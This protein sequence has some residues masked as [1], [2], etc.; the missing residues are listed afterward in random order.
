M[1]SLTYKLY[2]TTGLAFDKVKCT[3]TQYLFE[4]PCKN[5]SLCEPYVVL[6]NSGNYKIELWGASGGN[7]RKINSA[8]YNFGSAGNGSYVKGNIFLQKPTQLF[9]YLGGQGEDLITTDNVSYHMKGGWNFGGNG[10]NDYHDAG[11]TDPP[12]SGAGGGGGVDV[13]LEYYDINEEILDDRKLMRSIKSRIIVAGSGGGAEATQWPF[14]K[15]G[16]KLAAINSTDYILGGTQTLGMLGKGMDGL[17][18]INNMAGSGGS[19]SGYRGGYIVE[20]L[21]AGKSFAYG[22]AGGSSYISGHEGCISP[23]PDPDSNE[24]DGTSIHFSGLFFTSTQMLAGDEQM[25]DPSGSKTKGHFGNGVCRITI[26]PSNFCTNDFCF[27]NFKLF[28]I[29]VFISLQTN[30]LFKTRFIR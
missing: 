17:S 7:A 28:P 12:E 23:S 14:G 3:K 1:A 27:M 4:Y 15:P 8:E 21:A 25:I 29:F 6:L 2:N 9:I 18:S 19:G 30:I 13:R 22:G 20:E 5:R 24:S 10:G 11:D 26:L 16:G